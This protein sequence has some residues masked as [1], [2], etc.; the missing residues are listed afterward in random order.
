MAAT[1]LVLWLLGVFAAI[2]LALAAIG[3]YAV[4]AYA[5]RQRSREI[6]MRVALGATRLDITWLIAKQGGLIA[7]AG[8]GLGVG[9]GLIAA[10]SMSALLYQVSTTDPQT[11][12]WSVALL[13][14]TLVVACYVPARRAARIDA[15]RTL[16]Q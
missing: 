5:V 15:A 4:M 9:A 14:A 3:V 10:R 13:A 16:A 7:V 8:L 12:G 6:G 2:A 1:T 11:L